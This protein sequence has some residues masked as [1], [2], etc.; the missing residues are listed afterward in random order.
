MPK[1]EESIM[2]ELPRIQSQITFLYYDDLAHIA[3]FYENT[4][5]LTLVENQGFAR[6]YRLTASSFIG[7]VDGVEGFHSPKPDNAVLVT[8][9]VEDVDGWYDYL[10]ARGVKILREPNTYESIQ[11]RCFFFEDPGGYTYEVQ[12]FLKPASAAIFHSQ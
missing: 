11:V 12:Q 10:S 2:A 4:M 9:A 1:K 3:D 6:I 5:Q 8:M 7:I